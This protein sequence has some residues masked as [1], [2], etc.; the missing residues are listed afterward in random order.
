MFVP[1][2]ASG[3]KKSHNLPADRVD[4]AQIRTFMHIAAITRQRQIVLLVPA[5]V[6]L[7]DNVLD[8]KTGKGKIGL[9][10][11]AVLAAVSRSLS[12]RGSRGR[13]HQTGFVRCNTS[14]AFACNTPI[15]SITSTND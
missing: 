3:I 14:R 11:P 12:H 2:I 1:V 4:A 9:S 10:E 6:L 8:L 13:V 5:T 7:S 15:K